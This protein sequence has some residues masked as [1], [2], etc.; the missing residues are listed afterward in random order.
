MKLNFAKERTF[1]V[2]A[3]KRLM[4][5]VV[6]AGIPACRRAGLPSPAGKTD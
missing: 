3:A 1:I 5:A 6:A 4:V 2:P